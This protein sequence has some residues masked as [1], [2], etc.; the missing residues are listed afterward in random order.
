MKMADIGS[1]RTMG[2]P[3]REYRVMGK[4]GIID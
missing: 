3:Y 1:K 4:R 2:E